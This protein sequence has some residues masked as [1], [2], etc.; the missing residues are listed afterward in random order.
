[1]FLFLLKHDSQSGNYRRLVLDLSSEEWSH[2]NSTFEGRWE[3]LYVFLLKHIFSTV[4]VHK[5]TDICENNKDDMVG[6]KKVA[7]GICPF[8]WAWVL[9]IRT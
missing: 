8:L 9:H 2:E 3:N 6:M 5:H 1:M 7:W 4:F